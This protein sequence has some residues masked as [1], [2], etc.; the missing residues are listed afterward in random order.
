MIDRWT[1]LVASILALL[2]ITQHVFAQPAVPSKEACVSAHSWAQKLRKQ[3]Q[4]IAAKER[5]QLCSQPQCPEP[6]RQ[7]CEPWLA[8]VEG[9]IPTVKFI[10]ESTVRVILDGKLL[11]PLHA[12]ERIQLDPGDHNLV[13]MV[14]GGSSYEMVVTVRLADRDREIALRTPT[15]NPSASPTI[16]PSASASNSSVVLLNDHVDEKRPWAT[17]TRSE[18]RSWV[19]SAPASAWV[20]TGFGVVSL[21][22]FGGFAISGRSRQTDMEQNCAPFCNKEDVSRMRRDYAVADIALGVA[23]VSFGAAA[24]L[25]LSS[26]SSPASGLAK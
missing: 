5:L 25:F 9:R 20:A 21:G 22:V 23:I 24:W 12:A 14:V 15:P 3:D 6:V 2:L 4:L 19:K 17:D 8:E 16:L 10:Y 18:Q 1:G 11:D 26:P 7:D 13:V